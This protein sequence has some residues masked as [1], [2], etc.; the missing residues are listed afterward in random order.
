MAKAKKDIRNSSPEF[1]YV[2][3]D[4][5]YDKNGE[6]HP[7][8]D[9]NRDFSMTAKA[10]DDYHCKVVNDLRA[11]VKKIFT[12]KPLSELYRVVYGGDRTI[13]IDNKTGDRLEMVTREKKEYNNLYKAVLY[14]LLKYRGVYGSE[15]ERFLFKTPWTYIGLMEY[16]L[17]F[18]YRNKYTHEDVMKLHELVEAEEDPEVGFLYILA[19]DRFRYTKKEIDELVKN[20][21]CSEKTSTKRRKCKKSYEKKLKECPIKRGKALAKT[22][23]DLEDDDELDW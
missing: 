6:Y 20:A 9:S 4:G 15:I 17:E 19:Y 11:I 10:L 5:Y 18:G 14:L 8:P 16:L 13:L 2:D 1:L 3:T 7:F 12:P 23:D 22:R 21:T